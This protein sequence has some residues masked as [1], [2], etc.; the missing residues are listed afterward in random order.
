MRPVTNNVVKGM[1]GS[2][3]TLVVP[4]RFRDSCRD[5]P[6]AK[7]PHSSWGPCPEW[8]HLAHV[9]LI[10]A[11]NMRLLKHRGFVSVVFQPLLPYYVHS[12]VGLRLP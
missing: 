12:E 2:G 5:E 1:S 6:G 10:T 9:C 3:I 11:T 8:A 4:S 7:V